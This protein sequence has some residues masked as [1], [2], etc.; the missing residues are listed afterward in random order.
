MATG[1]KYWINGV[2]FEAKSDGSEK[3]WL[4]G[5]PFL[6]E[7]DSTPSVTV[8]EWFVESPQ[9]R[10][11]AVVI[12]HQAFFAPIDFTPPPTPENL[13]WLFTQAQ[14]VTPLPHTQ[15]GWITYISVVPPFDPS[16]SLP[17]FSPLSLPS[18]HPL[19]S[20]RQP[21]VIPWFRNPVPPTGKPEIETIDVFALRT[22]PRANMPIAYIRNFYRW[23]T[24]PSEGS[25]EQSPGSQPQ[26]Y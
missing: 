19:L 22:V 18:P 26:N 21:Y 24:Y 5:T 17:W 10:R 9:P 13:D 11:A 23:S 3:Y 6:T 8:S 4:N 2:P 7:G 16:N 14:R 1:V 20:Y 15:T 12:Q 25:T